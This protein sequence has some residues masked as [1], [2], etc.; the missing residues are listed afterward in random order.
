MPRAPTNRAVLRDATRAAHGAAEARWVWQGRFRSRGAYGDWLRRL[1]RAHCTLGLP[2]AQVLGDA[3]Q[4]RLRI[5]AL[6]SDLGLSGAGARGPEPLDLGT[7]WGVAYALNGSALGASSLLTSG[8]VSRDWP[9]A[10][11]RVLRD[12]ARGGGLR[13]FF[14]D[15]D[16]ASVPRAQM[17]QGAQ[18]VFACL[19]EAE[20]AAVPF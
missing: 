5:R 2:A 3:H 6:R 14:D 1:L 20:E 12:Y 11:L 18:A 10:Y 8:A 19:A 13:A 7:A 4:E 9:Q 17:V 15:L 16:A